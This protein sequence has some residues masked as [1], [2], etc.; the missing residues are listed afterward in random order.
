MIESAIFLLVHYTAI[1]IFGVLSCGLG[2]KITQ[3]VGYDSVWERIA[4]GTGLGLGLIASFGFVLGLLHLL[5]R[6]IVIGALVLIAVV[7]AP[8]ILEVGRAFIEAVRVSRRLAIAGAIL[9]LLSLFSISTF[10]LFPPFYFTDATSFHLAFA[11]IFAQTH[12]VSPAPYLRYPVFTILNEMLFALSLLIL[13]DTLAQLIQFLMMLLVGLTVFAW[14]KRTFSPSVGLLAAALW[15]ATPMVIWLG[16]SAGIDVGLAAFLTLG[17]CAFF[18]WTRTRDKA[19]LILSGV[20]IGFAAGSKYSALIFLGCLGLSTL[21]RAL[22]ERDWSYPVIFGAISVGVAA[23]W[24]LFNWYYSGN[25]VFPFFGELF[26]YRMWSPADLLHQMDELGSWGTGR[27]LSSFILLPWNLVFNQEKFHLSEAALLPFYLL[28]LPIILLVA[29][30]NNS[31]RGLVGLSL[32]YLIYWF[33]SAQIIR[34]LMP[35]L[36]LLCLVTAVLFEQGLAHVR[37]SNQR[38]VRNRILSASALL[39]LMYGAFFVLNLERHIGPPPLTRAGRENFYKR[40]RVSY[41]AY[42][43]LN[44]QRGKDYTVYALNESYMAY[45]ADGVQI[46]DAFGPARYSEIIRQTNGQ[47]LYEQL[48][49]LHTTHLLVNFQT[50]VFPNYRLPQD[51]FFDEH[52]KPVYM[53]PYVRL[54]EIVDAPLHREVGAQLLQNASFE[55]L[56]NNQPANWISYGSPI[57]DASGAYSHTGLSAVQSRGA[58]SGYFQGVPVKSDGFYR[59]GE[60]ARG[61]APKQ[62]ARLQL[63]WSSAQGQ[64]LGTDI[65]VI[66]VGPN[67]KY[68][69]LAIL[70]P[71][72]AAFG[73]VYVTAEG[74]NSVWLDD[75]SFVEVTYPP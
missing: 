43:F 9:S 17:T 72:Q 21:Y 11:K 3:R 8:T 18:N 2:C 61:T 22:R 14:G 34:Y 12:V 10:A 48:K 68:Y 69:E 4:V 15:L 55:E 31:I 53:R 23:P 32:T 58:L 29:I 30:K 35:I 60:Y 49:A 42:Q 47:A 39:L 41:E 57:G 59:L 24:Y 74:E 70:P 51:D 50:I 13:D 65:E 19:W 5:Y 45:F 66:E 46:G 37:I 16:A 44:N 7:C 54:Y 25:P 40:Y 1:A 33:F 62:R 52:F 26:G 71:K 63:Q 64:F 73:A 28:S 6:E 20:F 75:F 27:T 38:T 67:W 56:Q 36:P